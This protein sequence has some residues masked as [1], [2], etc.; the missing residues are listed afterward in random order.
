MVAQT[1]PRGPLACTGHPSKQLGRMLALAA[2]SGTAPAPDQAVLQGVDCVQHNLQLARTKLAHGARQTPKLHKRQCLHRVLTF[3]SCNTWL[4]TNLQQLRQNQVASVYVQGMLL[5]YQWV[6]CLFYSPQKQLAVGDACLFTTQEIAHECS[7]SQ[8][9]ACRSTEFFIRCIKLNL[10]GA[11]QTK[12]HEFIPFFC[13]P[14]QHA[15]V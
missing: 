7:P 15:T 4:A 5:E 8:A 3:Q 11:K 1:L 13:S 10:A 2:R 14:W 12:V 6:C 9:Q